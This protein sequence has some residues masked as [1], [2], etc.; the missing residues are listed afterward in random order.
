MSQ[1]ARRVAGAL[2]LV[3]MV[4]SSAA[5]AE[6]SESDHVV[7]APVCSSAAIESAHRAAAGALVEVRAPSVHGF[8]TWGLGFSFGS[9]RWVATALHLVENGRGIEVVSGEDVREAT[10]IAAGR[11][12]GIAILRL[13]RPLAATAV[14]RVTDDALQ[15]DVRAA[16]ASAP[17]PAP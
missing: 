5:Q 7:E 4:C 14:A 9:G 16:S 12:H 3:T 1:H 15:S 11:E 8:P 10:L 2:A 6:D 13:D 17:R